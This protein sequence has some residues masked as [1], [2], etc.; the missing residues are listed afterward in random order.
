MKKKRLI[1]F[2][3][4]AV[5]FLGCFCINTDNVSAA[6][7]KRVKITKNGQVV[8]AFNKV[9][10]KYKKGVGNTNTGPY[11][12][13]GYVKSY[14]SKVYGVTV[15]NLMK[16][17][18]P[19]A[20]KGS[21]EV[22]S[23]PEVGD[24]GYQKNSSGGGH[25]FIIKK[26]NG[27]GTYTII[28]QNWKWRNGG[29][30]YCYVNRQVSKKTS[31]F[32]VYRW[33]KKPSAVITSAP[34]VKSDK[35]AYAS[36]SNAKI[37]WNKVSNAT[38]YTLK[39]TGP[40]DY[41]VS[42]TVS[43][44]S[45][46]TVKSLKKGTYTATVTASNGRSKKVGKHSF[47]VQ[48]S[49][50][51]APTIKF[52]KSSYVVGNNAK[53]SW[54]KVS[55]ATKYT[56][57]ITGPS[58]YKV[59]Q[60]V[61]ANSS[62]T[63]KSLKNGKYTIIVTALN[64]VSK[65]EGS[66]GFTVNY[67]SGKIYP[68]GMQTVSNGIYHIV[69]DLD[70]TKTLNIKSASKENG[71]NLQIWS[72]LNDAKQAFQVTYL[73]NGYY[74]ITNVN[75]G[76]SLDVKSGGITPK[77]NVQQWSY[78]GTNNQQ[79]V[80]KM[81]N[82][83]SFNIISK[84]NSLYLDV[85]DAKT[86]NGTNVQ[87][88]TNN[89]NN[90]QKWRF[91]AYGGSTGK[92]A[93]DGTYHIVSALDNTKNLDVKSVSKDNGANIQLWATQH[94][95]KQGFKV[96]YLGNGYYKII[97]SNSG[98][99]LDVKS[100][101][102]ASGTNV[103]QWSYSGTDNQKW[104][105]KSAGSGYYYIIAKNSGLYLD[106]AGGKSDNG[107]NVQV[108]LGNGTAS[109]KWKLKKVTD[110]TQSGYAKYSGVDY[111]KLTSN[112]YR[113]AALNKAK[114]MV[115]VQWKATCDFVTWA[116]SKGSYNSVAATDGTTKTKF[117]KG[118][119]YTGVPYSMTNR[120]Y[121]DTKWIALLNKGIS[122][123]GMEATYSGYPV[124]GTKYG[125]DCS[126]FVCK[127]YNSAMGTSINLNTSAMLSSSEFKKL[128]SFSQL[129]PGDVF[130]KQGHVMMYVG[131]S[132]SNYAVFESCAGKSKCSYNVYSASALSSYKAYKYTGFGD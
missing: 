128:S 100:K 4:I 14:Y 55:N 1:S 6:S 44:N 114:Q 50:K 8:D 58:S 27:N 19:K 97:N 56:L 105:L 59:S 73:N 130:L 99:S 121:D 71:A 93:S 84:H 98:K 29:S 49:V 86:S 132:G 2:I 60:T 57:K 34:T 23:K 75:S 95:P 37:S 22:T 74:K 52:D 20:S 107:T 31:G 67:K 39:I 87:L 13:A 53:I 15:N 129:K 36:G 26:V 92:T 78:S 61:S 112:K 11:S 10:A 72:T 63:I 81:T 90:A 5:M 54:N 9:Q 3:L 65:K 89:G 46:Y 7:Q 108:Y 76:K 40:N 104:I 33:S 115:I 48:A 111:T 51:T 62:Y 88:Y 109:Q 123:S 17:R 45:S 118:K 106:A 101:G 119:T 41:M 18:T 116:S 68:K 24:I 120:T 102:I 25:W 122:T 69:S 70:S 91:V 126:Y 66:K 12:C 117:V 110:V 21:F 30:T 77:T 96:T 124:A 80:I 113:L 42:K 16:G 127:A 28:E 131:K 79:W 32:K 94:D 85:E 82:D 64:D 103:Q 125:I 38:K 43:A 47:F 35:K 83:G